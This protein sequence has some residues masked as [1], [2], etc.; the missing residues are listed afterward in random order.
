MPLHA[1]RA[2]TPVSRLILAGLP[3]LMAGSLA[4][5]EG[6]GSVASVEKTVGEWAKVRAETVRLETDWEAEH[7]LL[8]STLKALQ[9]RA[10]ALADD[11]KSLSAKTAGERESLATLA[12]ENAA[13]EA[14]LGAAAARLAKVSAQLVELRHSLPPRLSQALELPYRSLADPKLSPGE[15]MQFVTTI[16]NRCAQFNSTITYGE[17]PL[18]I[19][20]VDGTRLL[21]VIYWG[22]SHAYALDRAGG[23]AYLGSPEAQGWGWEATPDAAKS[24]A[25]LIDIY[26]DKSDPRFV[27]V[28]AHFAN[29]LAN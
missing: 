3:W 23:K 14:A 4:A 12:A 5:A 11:K 2:V 21:E 8:Q 16:L 22:A 9:E 25:E 18:T 10:K 1:L 27:E 17:E 15:R 28:P 7:E 29:A 24:V 13:S 6:S 19:P 26:R 20:G